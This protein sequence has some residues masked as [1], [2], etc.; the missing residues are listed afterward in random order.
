MDNL[1]DNEIF[2]MDK[3]FLCAQRH[4]QNY[5]VRPSAIQLDESKSL[6]VIKIWLLHMGRKF[7]KASQNIGW[8]GHCQSAR[9][10]AIY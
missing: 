9:P 5:F 4:L 6:L 2:C 7:N 10:E 1:V 8:P 3:Y